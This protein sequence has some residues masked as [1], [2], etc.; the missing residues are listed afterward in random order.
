MHACRSQMTARQLYAHGV[1]SCTAPTF[2]VYRGVAWRDASQVDSRTWPPSPA[3]G[4][5]PRR[6]GF[7][8]AM[9]PAERKTERAEAPCQFP[10]AASPVRPPFA[11]AR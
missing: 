5:P 9:P 1:S 2:R 6:G 8:R 4:P 10:L 7:A 3:H 11:G